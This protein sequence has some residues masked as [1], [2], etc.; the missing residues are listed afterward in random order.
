MERRAGLQFEEATIKKEG[1][2]KIWRP[3]FFI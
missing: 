1:L 3:S 2:Y